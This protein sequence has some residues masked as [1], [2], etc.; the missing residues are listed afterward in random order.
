MIPILLH[1]PSQHRRG[2]L[3]IEVFLRNVGHDWIVAFYGC[4]D[5][6]QQINPAGIKSQ[7]C[8]TY[9]M[10]LK[11]RVVELQRVPASQL[12][13]NLKTWRTHPISQ[14]DTLR[15]LLLEIGISAAITVER[16]EGV[17]LLDGHLRTEIISERDY[18]KPHLSA[19]AGDAPFQNTSDH[20]STAAAS[21]P[22]VTPKPASETVRTAPSCARS[23][24]SRLFPQIW[25]DLPGTQYEL[26][27]LQCFSSFL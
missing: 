8:R 26:K 5:F 25:T 11:D 4:M 19:N 16:P 3:L 22:S 15:G 7:N 24:V 23:L 14:Q 6:G 9:G 17:V 10:K 12:A 2:R 27:T 18:P 13:S 1:G 20:Q 21:G